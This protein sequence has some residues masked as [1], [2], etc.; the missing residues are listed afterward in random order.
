[1][2]DEFPGSL[3]NDFCDAAEELF[4]QRA[5]PDNTE[6][7]IWRDHA[8]PLRRVAELGGQGAQ[9]SHLGVTRPEVGTRQQL[10]GLQRAARTERI[11]NGVDATGSGRAQQGSQHCRKQMRMFVGVDVRDTY[12]SRLQLANL[13]ARLSF[14]F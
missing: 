10:T 4:V 5:S 13:R 6:R 1:M 12:A 2:T 11:A 7:A 14:N 3:G 8:L 9:N